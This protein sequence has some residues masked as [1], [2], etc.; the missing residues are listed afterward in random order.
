MVTV[1]IDYGTSNSEVVLFDGKEHHYIELD[2]DSKTPFKIRSSV[3]IYYEDDLPLPPVE[4]IDDKVQF[5]K[6]AITA[7]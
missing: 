2:K 3:F 5:L 7:Q 4:V 6:R 1:G